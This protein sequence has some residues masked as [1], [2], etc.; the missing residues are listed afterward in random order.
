MAERTLVIIKPD[1]V[2]RHLVGEIISRFEKKGLKLVGAKFL[3]MSKELAEQLYSVH[4]GKTFH[5]PLV[6]Y[7]CSSPVLVTAWE[8]N[9]VI[10]MARKLMGATFGFEAE[11]GTI[12]GDLGSSIRYNLVHGSDSLESAKREIPIFFKD[13]EIVD[14]EL[15]NALWLYGQR[16]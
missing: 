11:P 8:A 6:A 14:Y 13:E 12:R 5:D 4:E 15:T 1:G 2:Q 9:G 7:I 3:R 10:D 16:E